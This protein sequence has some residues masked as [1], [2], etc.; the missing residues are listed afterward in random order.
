MLLIQ[1][2]LDLRWSF[3]TRAAIVVD[4]AQEPQ[5]ATLG[6][7]VMAATGLSLLGVSGQSYDFTHGRRIA[8]RP[9]AASGRIGGGRGNKPV[10]P[11]VS[12]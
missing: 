10:P 3:G 5:R 7:L 11:G 4:E 1:L 6:S 9:A 8:C 12:S 2:S